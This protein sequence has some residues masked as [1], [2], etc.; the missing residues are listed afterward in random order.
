[1]SVAYLC[2]SWWRNSPLDQHCNRLFQA[3]LVA[4]NWKSVTSEL[5]DNTFADPS[6]IALS[7]LPAISWNLQDANTKIKQLNCPLV[8]WYIYP[9]DFYLKRNLHT[10]FLFIFSWY[11]YFC[12]LIF[13]FHVYHTCVHGK[14]IFF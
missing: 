10:L 1:M 12:T 2:V 9:G 6:I 7:T 5:P 14:I 13:I 3:M 11:P 8:N 4:F